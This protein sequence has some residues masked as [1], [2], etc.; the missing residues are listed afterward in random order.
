[1]VG[2]SVLKYMT[3]TNRETPAPA[4]TMPR[5]TSPFLLSKEGFTDDEE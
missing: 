1:M 2:A 4:R 3:N 5:L